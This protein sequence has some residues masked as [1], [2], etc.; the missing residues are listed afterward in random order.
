MAT[1]TKGITLGSVVCAEPAGRQCGRGRFATWA[2]RSLR[3]HRRLIMPSPFPGMDPY[4]EDD[5]LWLIF[6]HQLVTRL[7]QDLLPGLVDRYRARVAQR[8]YVTEQPLFT[9]IIREMHQ[10][11]YIEIRQ[12]S[13]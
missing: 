3:R 1:C 6:H 5:K 2:P 7:Y 11:E 4:L 12:R 8:Q 9:S 10:E 13:D